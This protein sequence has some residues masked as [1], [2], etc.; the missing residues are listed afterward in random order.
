MASQEN[1]PAWPSPFLANPPVV[2]VVRH[3]R[4]T[5][6]G[7][8]VAENPQNLT[9]YFTRSYQPR[10]YPQRLNAAHPARQFPNVMVGAKKTPY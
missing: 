5:G 10:V 9:R 3:V 6:A 1:N 8:T 7:E 2:Q 4:V